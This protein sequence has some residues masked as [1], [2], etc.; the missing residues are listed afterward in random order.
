MTNISLN[1]NSQTKKNQLK[2]EFCPPGNLFLFII[3]SVFSLKM[4]LNGAIPF[5]EGG[6]RP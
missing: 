5:S 2:R 6:I 3:E 1:I 4:N